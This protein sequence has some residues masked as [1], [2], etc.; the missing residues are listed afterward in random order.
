MRGCDSRSLRGILKGNE[1]ASLPNMARSVVMKLFSA[2]QLSFSYALG[3]QEVQA[4]SDVSFELERGGFYAVMGPSGSGKSTL[5][6]LLGLIEDVSGGSLQF[7][8]AEMRDMSEAKKNELRRFHFGFYPS[9][10]VS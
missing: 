3:T 9:R 8:D 1:A 5:L 4:L 2:K 7:G 6:N 10:K